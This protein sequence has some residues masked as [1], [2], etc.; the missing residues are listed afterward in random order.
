MDNLDKIKYIIKT[1]NRDEILCKQ[2]QLYI[3]DFLANSGVK[4]S[5]NSDGTYINLD[6]LSPNIIHSVYL[7]VQR[8]VK[9]N[10]KYD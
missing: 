9:A 1:I 4:Y 3:L 10:D 8:C 5:Q 6:K 7:I 2:Q